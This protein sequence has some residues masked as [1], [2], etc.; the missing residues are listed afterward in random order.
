MEGS[1]PD[2][3]TDGV[4]TES[5]DECITLLWG[6]RC[7]VIFRPRGDGTFDRCESLLRACRQAGHVIL[8]VDGST[9]L[10]TSRTAVDA[11]IF[12]LLRGH[13]H[14][15]AWLLFT[16][17]HFSGDIPQALLACS[18]HL[19][20]FRTTQPAVLDRLEAD[21]DL[22]RDAV[23][24]LQQGECFVVYQGFDPGA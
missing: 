14:A 3:L 10:M 17:H 13:R 15:P 5:V 19:F 16:T 9:Y 8:L 6:E 1:L 20:V 22:S 18:P 2:S 23:T 12:E 7:N 11:P 4:V 24:T 21:Y